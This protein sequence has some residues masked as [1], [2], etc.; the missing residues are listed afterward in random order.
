MVPY[1]NLL[2]S[3]SIEYIVLYSIVPNLLYSTI[4]Y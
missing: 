1:H 2:V 4:L 3:I